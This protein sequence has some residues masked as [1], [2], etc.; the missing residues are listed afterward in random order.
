[1]KP[2]RH[3]E[4]VFSGRNAAKKLALLGDT[5]SW[6]K[7]NSVL[8]CPVLPCDSTVMYIKT[9]RFEYEDDLCMIYIYIYIYV[10]T[11]HVEKRRISLFWKQPMAVILSSR[12]RKMAIGSD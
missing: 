1:M 9:C 2:P 11:H 3:R 5:V 7:V 6:R 12:N 4:C 10:Y 8:L